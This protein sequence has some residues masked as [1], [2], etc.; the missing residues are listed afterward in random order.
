M[1]WTNVKIETIWET[2][3]DKTLLFI[4]TTNATEMKGFLELLIFTE[5]FK[6]GNESVESLFAM[7]STGR[8]VFCCTMSM[9]RFMLLLVCLHFDD[10][11]TRK[12]RKQM[13]PIAAILALF[14][15]LINNSQNM[16]SLGSSVCIDEMLVAFRGRCKFKVFILKKPAIWHPDCVSRWYIYNAY[17]Y[18][19]RDSDG[20]SLSEDEKKLSVPSQSIVRLVKPIEKKNKSKYHCRQLVWFYWVVTTTGARPYIRRNIEKNKEEI[21]LNFLPHRSREVN[22]TIYGFHGNITLLS[23]VPKKSKEVILV[24]STHHVIVPEIIEYYNCTILENK[25]GPTLGTRFRARY[26]R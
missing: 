13:D 6:L 16:Y 4:R 24:F 18:T 10:P 8:D 23:H 15:M 17:I 14:D 22:S 1:T 21:P 2:Y 7:D 9:K 11:V 19:G 25:F 20:I 5:I 26:T 12:Q 3:E